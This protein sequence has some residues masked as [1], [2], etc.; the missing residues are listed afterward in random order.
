MNQDLSI[1][2]YQ[3]LTKQQCLE[4]Y[5]S[6]IKY[7]I[8]NPISKRKNHCDCH[9]IIPRW[10]CKNRIWE[11]SNSNKVNL[12][13]HE[14]FICHYLLYKYFNNGPAM[15]AFAFFLCIINNLDIDTI[16]IYET[17]V[18]Y[19][20]KEKLKRG[21]KKINEYGDDF[22]NKGTTGTRWWNNGIIQI[23][24]KDCPGEGFM[25]GMLSS[26]KEKMSKTRLDRH[27]PS[28]FSNRKGKTYE[29]I[30]GEEKA[31]EIKQKLK[32]KLKK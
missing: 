6:I 23:V 30:Y 28:T 3:S 32:D 17:A 1:I 12:L 5:K 10:I 4:L 13:I 11:N 19:E 26:S 29:E 15:A 8:H 31:K 9:H 7:R 2:N 14:H 25:L 16:N 22:Y 24:A 20:N 21:N 18:K 27:I